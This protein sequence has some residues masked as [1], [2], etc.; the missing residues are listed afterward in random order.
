VKNVCLS[1]IC[2]LALIAVVNADTGPEIPPP[3]PGT[4]LVLYEYHYSSWAISDYWA[5]KGCNNAFYAWV[6]K[7]VQDNWQAGDTKH[8]FSLRNVRLNGYGFS[9]TIE[10][11]FYV[12]W[13]SQ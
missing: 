3:P 4:Q 2:F 1:L 10:A 11:D 12:W 7:K 9:W 5:V 8:E 13:F 6:E